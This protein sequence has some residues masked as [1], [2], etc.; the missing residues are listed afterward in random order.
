[1]PTKHT[2]ID[3][4]GRAS[5]IIVGR[6]IANAAN[7]VLEGAGRIAILTQP[8]VSRLAAAVAEGVEQ[9]GLI[10]AVR[11]LPDRDDAKNLVTVEAVFEWLNKLGFTRSDMAIAIGGGAL[12][13]LVGFAAATYMRGIEVTY[14]PTTLLAAVDASIGGKTGVNVGGKNLAGV[15]RHPARVVVDLDVLEQLPVELL[16]EGAAEAVKAG[17]I[18]DPTIL[19]EYEA[20]GVRAALDRIV[21][22]AI[23]V[24]VRTVTEDFRESG[25]R[26]ILNYGHTIGH[27]VETATGI[28]HGEAVA[29]GM[30][31]AGRVSA[32]VTGFEHEARQRG[33]I[34]KIGLPVQAPPVDEDEVRMLMDRDKKRDHAGVRMVLLEDF[35]QPI[36]THVDEG[37]LTAGL[38]A[39]GIGKP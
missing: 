5:E 16:R 38:Q 11:I 37:L 36:V 33:I 7:L 9:L 23:A 15:F 10:A 22:A 20:R 32:M 18:A 27:A 12:T 31:A 3:E 6:D 26:A 30:V 17:F 13:D 29:I 21:P 2:I 28:S 35:G 4:S 14:L 39:V 34:E 8:S 25:K 24:K 19:D 1:M